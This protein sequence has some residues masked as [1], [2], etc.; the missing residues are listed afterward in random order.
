MTPRQQLY[1]KSLIQQIHT[2][3]RYS[4]YFRHNR[5]DYEALLQEHFGVTSSKELEIDQLVI[6]VNYFNFQQKELPIQKPKKQN[7]TMAQLSTIRSMWA[8]Y[9][10]DVS[11]DALLRFIK[12]QFKKQLLHVKNL[13]FEEAQKLIPMLKRMQEQK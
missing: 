9:A 10:D 5:D 13:S 12:R 7:A 4:E 3:K 11:D 1:H 2:S 6:L 8:Q